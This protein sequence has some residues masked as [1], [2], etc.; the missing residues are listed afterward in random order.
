MGRATCVAAR[1]PAPQRARKR[2]RAAPK[3][4]PARSAKT[5]RS[6]LRVEFDDQ[7]RFHLHRVGHVAQSRGA[8][9]GRGHLVV[10]DFQV[11][12][13]VTL[14]RLHGLEDERELTRL[15]AHRDHVAFLHPV[16]GDVDALAVHG[17]VA[18]VD[19]LAGG[20][21]GRHELGAIDDRV[22]TALE[23][24][25]Q[26]LAGVALDALGFRVD[27][28]ELLL[29]HVAV[30]ALELLLGAQLGTEVRQLALA[31][32]AVL[33]RAVFALVQRRLGAAPDVLAHAAV[34]F[35]LGRRAFGHG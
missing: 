30:V 18:V 10:V 24:A 6:V 32:L 21:D 15:V 23:Q 14:G 22:E 11:I 7:V 2:Q 35:V 29:G 33:A 3:D 31:A 17:D 1:P 4:G 26:V 8:H 25:D 20:E 27:A 19:E 5:E 34:D 13:H 9:E 28:A 12:R 16:G